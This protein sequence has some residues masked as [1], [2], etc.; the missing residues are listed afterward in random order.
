MAV[1]GTASFLGLSAAVWLIAYCLQFIAYCLLLIAYCLLL[2]S[3]KPVRAHSDN[4]ESR[5]DVL[6]G[7]SM[8][9]AAGARMRLSHR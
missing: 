6:N 4:K 2:T 5:R 3:K 7:A 1:V 8:A 9:V